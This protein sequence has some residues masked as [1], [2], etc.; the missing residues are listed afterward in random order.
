MEENSSDPKKLCPFS[1]LIDI[2]LPPDLFPNDLSYP[3]G[4]FGQKI[5]SVGGDFF[6][7]FTKKMK[8]NFGTC[9]G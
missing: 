5:P 4:T 6:F 2:K 8:P 9:N 1:K 7:F 3:K